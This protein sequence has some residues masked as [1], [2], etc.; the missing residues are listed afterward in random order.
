MLNSSSF[1]PSLS[2]EPN[3]PDRTANLNLLFFFFFLLLFI[4]LFYL[5]HLLPILFL[6]LLL[7]FLLL[8]SL[9]L[10]L[11]LPLLSLFLLLLL[12]LLLFLLL[13]LLLLLHLLIPNSCIRVSL[14]VPIKNNFVV[15]KVFHQ[16]PHHY[17]LGYRSIVQ[18][19]VHFNFLENWGNTSLLPILRNH[20]CFN[21]FIENKEWR[22][23]LF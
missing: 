6:L 1:S 15:F 8:L 9:L 7:L 2:T 19:L 4:L 10:F 13:L 23:E 3:F 21:G 14:T 16:V 22:S 20:A 5:L 18:R 17:V 11:L 12:L